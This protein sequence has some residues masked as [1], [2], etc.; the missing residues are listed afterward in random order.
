MKQ[1]REVVAVDVVLL[2]ETKHVPYLFTL[3][4]LIKTQVSSCQHLDASELA[5]KQQTFLVTFSSGSSFFLSF[6]DESPKI[7]II[8][9]LSVTSFAGYTPLS[10]GDGGGTTCTV[11]VQHKS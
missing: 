8:I 6:F 1:L 10:N 3:A 11:L 4:V 5:Q 2:N 9:M 7:L